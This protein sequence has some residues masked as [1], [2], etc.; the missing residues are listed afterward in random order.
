M[1][2]CDM[3]GC[4]A[5]ATQAM[6]DRRYC[7]GCIREMGKAMRSLM[8]KFEKAKQQVNRSRQMGRG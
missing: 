8:G 2:T 6:D 1:K 3:E 4:E 7:M 5:E